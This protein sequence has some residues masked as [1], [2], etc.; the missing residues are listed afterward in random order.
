MLR[1]GDVPWRQLPPAASAWDKGPPRGLW[2][3][4]AQQPA[5]KQQEKEKGGGD[6]LAELQRAYAE[7]ARLFGEGSAVATEAK[8]EVEA[9][10]ARADQARPVGQTL[11]QLGQQLEKKSQQVELH[12]KKAEELKEE[13]AKLEAKIAEEEEMVS[14][15]EAEV[16]GLRAKLA[17]SAQSPPAPAVGGE[18]AQLEREIGEL[19]AGEALTGEDRE[20]CRGFAKV[21]EA[22]LKARRRAA[23]AAA[24]AA[25]QA[26]RLRGAS[27]VDEDMSGQDGGPMQPA[28]VAPGGGRAAADE[29]DDEGMEPADDF[30][31]KLYQ[32]D[33]AD[34]AQLQAFRQKAKATWAEERQSKRRRG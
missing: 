6:R 13:K 16:K 21:K 30:W 19:L 20:S 31:D 28:A 23:A 10:K 29:A 2:Q 1:L 25:A 24:E 15:F 14:R 8:K 12:R 33:K 18:L 17:E 3:Q 34:I 26:E 11:R 7:V 4:G 32:G 27:Q 22:V 9:E 5:G